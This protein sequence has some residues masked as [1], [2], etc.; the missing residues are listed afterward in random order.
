M[1][2]L[3]LLVGLILLLGVTACDKAEVVNAANTVAD[4]PATGI[5]WVDMG[6]GAL[7]LVLTVAGVRTGK[8][9]YGAV[10]YPKTPF[11]AE[12]IAEIESGLFARGWVKVAPVALTGPPP[13][14]PA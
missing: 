9:V 8:A 1:R 4:A 12:E 5:P 3:S 6:I 14:A 13:S 7:G 11:T 10:Q 2:H